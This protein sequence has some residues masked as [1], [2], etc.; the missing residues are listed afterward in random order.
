[1]G[2]HFGHTRCVKQIPAMDV[3]WL[4]FTRTSAVACPSAFSVHRH[5]CG[6]V[7]V[8]WLFLPQKFIFSD[9]AMARGVKLTWN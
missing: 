2:M 5:V 8:T 9:K 4:E 1:M 3:R 7:K 6:S